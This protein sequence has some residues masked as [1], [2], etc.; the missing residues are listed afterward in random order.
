MSTYHPD[1]GRVCVC[2]RLRLEIKFIALNG[3]TS[4]Y[5]ISGRVGFAFTSHYIYPL[6]RIIS[7][8]HFKDYG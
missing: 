1:S 6:A 5:F 7:F 8:I 4:S 3:D 2:A